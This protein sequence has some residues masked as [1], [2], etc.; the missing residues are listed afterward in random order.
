MEAVTEPAEVENLEVPAVLGASPMVQAALGQALWQA[1]LGQ[2]ASP[3]V[4]AV[5]AAVDKF[6]SW[7]S[8]QVSIQRHWLSSE[9]PQ[10]L[11]VA[12]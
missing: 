4:V 8:F 11:Q 10:A 1:A 3:L 12:D 6:Q 5:V 7:C 2:D 9:M